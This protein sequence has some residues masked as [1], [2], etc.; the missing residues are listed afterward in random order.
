MGLVK[1]SRS[2]TD[3]RMVI[4]TMLPDGRELMETLFPEFNR[5]EV[6]VVSDIKDNDRQALADML[7][8]ITAKI[9][10]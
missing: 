9:G 6:D 4:V 3:G 10:G 2:A 5:H 7:R 1:R 8:A